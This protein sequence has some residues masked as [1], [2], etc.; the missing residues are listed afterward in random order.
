MSEPFN[1]KEWVGLILFSV[2]IIGAIVYLCMD[3]DWSRY[4]RISTKPI[5]SSPLSQNDRIEKKLDKDGVLIIKQ[6]AKIRIEDK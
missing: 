4:Q 3:A 6:G 1:R 5:G 2:L